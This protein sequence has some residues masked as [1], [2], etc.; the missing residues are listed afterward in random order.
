MGESI[1]ICVDIPRSHE[2]WVPV[3][4]KGPSPC[5]YRPS[6][7]QPSALSTTPSVKPQL[8]AGLVEL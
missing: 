7:P 3:P 6:C 8:N 4:C 1:G 5:T 2:Q